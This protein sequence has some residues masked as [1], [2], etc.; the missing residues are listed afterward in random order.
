MSSII[1]IDNSGS[2]NNNELYWNEV[3]KILELNNIKHV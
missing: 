2:V 3:N 1:F